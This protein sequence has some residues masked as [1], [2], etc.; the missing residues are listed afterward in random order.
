MRGKTSTSTSMERAGWRGNCEPGSKHEEQRSVACLKPLHHAPDAESFGEA[1]ADCPV[2]HRHVFAPYN[3]RQWDWA[4][5]APAVKPKCTSHHA[6][7]RDEILAQ[8]AARGGKHQYLVKWTGYA[9][10][11]WTSASAME[12]TLA[13]DRWEAR[14]R[15]GDAHIGGCMAR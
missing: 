11:T 15:A 8:K 14:V 13:L 4:Q 1:W 12:D 7:S 10:P 3:L 6:P 2:D 5:R 9:R